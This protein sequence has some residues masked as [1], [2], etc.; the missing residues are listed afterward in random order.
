MD[1]SLFAFN[2]FHRKIKWRDLTG[3]ESDSAPPNNM[4][5]NQ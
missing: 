1:F 5:H 3:E 4:A 2:D